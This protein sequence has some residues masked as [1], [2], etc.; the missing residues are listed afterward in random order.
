MQMVDK[1]V[2]KGGEPA[3]I[4]EE[5]EQKQEDD[6][7]IPAKKEDGECQQV[8]NEVTEEANR[9]EKRLVM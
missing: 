9:G 6:G 8:L 5:T 2:D 7:D 1:N 3:E 4:L